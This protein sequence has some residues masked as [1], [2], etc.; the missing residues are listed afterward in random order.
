MFLSFSQISLQQ[1]CAEIRKCIYVICHSC[2]C[3]CQFYT[4]HCCYESFY[5]SIPAKTR[6]KSHHICRP[7]ETLSTQSRC[8]GTPVTHQKRS[9]SFLRQT[10]YSDQSAKYFLQYCLPHIHHLRSSCISAP[11]QNCGRIMAIFIPA[12]SRT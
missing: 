12:S 10:F 5:N 2:I 7:S 6:C 8:P 3:I 4:P 1:E 9:T 11:I